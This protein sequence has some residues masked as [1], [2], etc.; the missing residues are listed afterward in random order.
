[1]VVVL[2]A[3][4]VEVSVSVTA[5]AGTTAFDW[6]VTP[7]A[8]VPVD[9]DCD[10]RGRAPPKQT[11]NKRTRTNFT[12]RVY[13]ASSYQEIERSRLTHRHHGRPQK[14]ARSLP[15]LQQLLSIKTPR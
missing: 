14:P 3:V 11:I 1:L 12:L 10:H 5:A 7:P 8:T 13:I 4:L 9:D 2:R 6:S 15:E